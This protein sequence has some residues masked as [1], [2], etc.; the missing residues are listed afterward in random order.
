MDC[1]FRQINQKIKT[2]P[3]FSGRKTL[4]DVTPPVLNQ[5]VSVNSDLNQN[6]KKS[7]LY[8][9]PHKKLAISGGLF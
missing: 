2:Q 9:Q 7:V 5:T 3:I 1:F 8:A 6:T 4:H